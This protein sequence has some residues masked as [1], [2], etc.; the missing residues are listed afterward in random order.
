M[1]TFRDMAQERWE[2]AR[3]IY[4][5]EN[6][7]RERGYDLRYVDYCEDAETPGL[8]GQIRGAVNHDKQEV[9]VSIKANPSLGEV[10]AALEHELRHIRE[11]DWDCG[12]RD[13]F[14]RGGKE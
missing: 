2:A 9:K 14:G 3:R 4:A 11:P 8:L 12:S 6:G 10:A 13:V 1:T 7:I 5:A